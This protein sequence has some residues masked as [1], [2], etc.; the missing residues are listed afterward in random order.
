MSYCYESI[1]PSLLEGEGAVLVAV[2]MAEAK[3]MLVATGAFDERK[4]APVVARQLGVLDSW[5]FL[6]SLEYLCEQGELQRLS[7]SDEVGRVYVHGPKIRERVRHA[8]AGGST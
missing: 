4:L 2:V 5:Q 1:R 8:V 3:N 6:A 7:S